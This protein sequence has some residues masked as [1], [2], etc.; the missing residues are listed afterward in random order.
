MLGLSVDTEER[1]EKPESGKG[2]WGNLG[3]ELF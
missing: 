3:R 2:V 1:E